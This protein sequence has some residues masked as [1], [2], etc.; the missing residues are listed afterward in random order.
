MKTNVEWW[1]VSK[2]CVLIALS[3]CC[4]AVIM[5]CDD[6][7]SNP[8]QT[9][10]GQLAGTSW[11][12]DTVGTVMLHFNANGSTLQFA[13]T[14][15][16]INFPGTYTETG[17]AVTFSASGYDP[18]FGTLDLEGDGTFTATKLTATIDLYTNKVFLA[19]DVVTFTKQ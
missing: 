11:L 14:M 9:T 5:G 15:M 12:D 10:P 17:N 18:L 2:G 16:G 13:D 1:K 6:D 19:T 4:V 3:I 8:T 7:N